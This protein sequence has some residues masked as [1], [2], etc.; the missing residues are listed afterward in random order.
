MVNNV[1]DFYKNYAGNNNCKNTLNMT[2]MNFTKHRT[3][4]A[5]SGSDGQESSCLSPMDHTLSQINP[6]LDL[7]S[8][9]FHIQT[10][11]V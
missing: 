5:D 9:L 10:N 11:S 6:V 1:K 3:S 8:D 4:E 7:I 2:R